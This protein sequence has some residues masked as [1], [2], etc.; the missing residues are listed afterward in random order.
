MW[1]SSEETPDPLE[2]DPMGLFMRLCIGHL[3]DLSQQ[4][5]TKI[6]LH[7]SAISQSQVRLS[8]STKSG[9]FP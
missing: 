8:S 2:R 1:S 4:Q 6:P 9:V 3:G 5:I 7:L